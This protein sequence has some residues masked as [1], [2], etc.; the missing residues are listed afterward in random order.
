MQNTTFVSWHDALSRD[1]DQDNKSGG[2]CIPRHGGGGGWWFNACG[3]VWLTGQNTKTK[4]SIEKWKQIDYFY[5]GARGNSHDSWKEA[6]M[7]LVPV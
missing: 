7:L 1:R 2:S 6:E 4:T 5:G 3:G